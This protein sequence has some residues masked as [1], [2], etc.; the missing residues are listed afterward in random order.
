MDWGAFQGCLEDRLPWNL[1]LNDEEEFERCVEDFT[2]AIQE[3]IAASDPI[4]RHRANR[5]PPLYASIQDEISLKNRLRRQWQ[6]TRDP[7]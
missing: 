7:L 6:V 2:N 5:L 3:A 4:R 1:G